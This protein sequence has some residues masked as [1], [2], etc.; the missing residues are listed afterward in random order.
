MDEVLKPCPFCGSGNI[1]ERTRTSESDGE[2]AWQAYTECYD[3]GAQGPATAWYTGATD[4][5]HSRAIYYLRKMEGGWNT[6][7]PA[8]S[9]LPD[10]GEL[11]EKIIRIIEMNVC[12]VGATDL[13]NG[14]M[15]GADT[16]A[17]HI[18]AALT[19]DGSEDE[20]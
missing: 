5:P 18:I 16:A 10:V 9:S 15:L 2:E 11:R 1:D 6:R 12:E 14:E 4:D 19:T 17:D 7:T 8:P 13:E 20:R 3:C